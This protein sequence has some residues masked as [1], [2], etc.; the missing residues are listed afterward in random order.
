MSDRDYESDESDVS[1]EYSL[2]EDSDDSGNENLRI[3]SSSRDFKY[4]V[5]RE[6]T[7]RPV[8]LFLGATWSERSKNALSTILGIIGPK[9]YLCCMD[10]YDKNHRERFLSVFPALSIR[11]V[12]YL[13]K[14][15]NGGRSFRTYQD[16]MN[17]KEQL[18]LFLATNI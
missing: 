9:D 5:V 16:D 10:I 11:H 17:D 4:D 13:V 1:D 14:I 6:C 2:Y 7:H 18:S 8:T 12:P 15:I 3:V